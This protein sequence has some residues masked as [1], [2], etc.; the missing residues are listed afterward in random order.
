VLQSNSQFFNFS[1]DRASADQ[2]EKKTQLI[3]IL[4]QTAFINDE[5]YT[6]TYFKDITFGVLYEQIKAK[7]DLR[8]MINATLQQNISIPLQACVK[9]CQKL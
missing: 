3:Y 7:E 2:G 5:E 9:S 6:L 1:L 8:N 4:T